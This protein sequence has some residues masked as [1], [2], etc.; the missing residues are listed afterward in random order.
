MG[1][2][3]E[4]EEEEDDDDLFMSSMMIQPLPSSPSTLSPRLKKESF[5]ITGDPKKPDGPWSQLVR[6]RG[7]C[8]K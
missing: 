3:D 4:D 7:P 1:D 6:V 5:K 8:R 2:E